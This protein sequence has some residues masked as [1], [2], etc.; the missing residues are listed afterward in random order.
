MRLE[1]SIWTAAAE[2][3]FAAACVDE[4]ETRHAIVIMRWLGCWADP[5]EVCR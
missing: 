2:H 5:A 1:R 4:W 3:W